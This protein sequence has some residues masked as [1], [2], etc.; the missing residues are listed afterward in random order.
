MTV[1]VAVRKGTR[2][3]LAADSLVNFGGQRFA[4]S[5]CQFHKIYRFGD[6]LMVWA[7][8]SLYT[9][10]LT[11]FT[12]EKPPPK[13]TTEA[14][15]FSFFIQFWHSMRKEY[16]FVS[17]GGASSPFAD[18]ESTFLLANAGGIF[19]VASDMDVTRFDEYM[20]I[21]SGGKYALGALHVLYPQFSD[22]G[23][24]ARRAVQ[25][26]IDMDVYCGG[27]IDLAEVS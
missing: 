2:I 12:A 1:A 26:G 5:N 25:V 10:M 8:W 14:E 18:L 27:P 9:E 17:Q 3:V 6:C 4:A 19:R 13:L 24:I 16:S 15:V 7:G 20:A 21:G 22:P 11:A 23:E